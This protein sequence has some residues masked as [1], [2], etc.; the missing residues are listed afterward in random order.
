MAIPVS[1]EFGQGQVSFWKM[2]EGLGCRV[3]GLRMLGFYC[4]DECIYENK[5]KGGVHKR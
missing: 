2:S 5:D 3:L 1:I 4:F